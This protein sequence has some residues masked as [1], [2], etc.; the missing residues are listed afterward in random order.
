LRCSPPHE[1][2][3]LLGRDDDIAAVANLLHTSRV[4]SI[5][6]PGGLGKTRL[7][8]VVSRQAEQRVV[9]LVAL[10]GVTTDDDVVSEV[11]SVLGVGEFRR[12]PVGHVAVPSDVVTGVAGALGPGPALLV[13]DNCEQVIR[14]A[15]ELVQALVSVTRDLRVLTT[16]RARLGLSS[17]SV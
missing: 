15:A 1:P 12:T 3:P 9:H 14:G 13:L 10:A 11:A 2:N 6:G 5:V 16:S 17:E 4:T 7:A 8:Y